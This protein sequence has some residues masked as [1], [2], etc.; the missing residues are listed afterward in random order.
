MDYP[1][2][3]TI[4]IT[5]Q[6]F[7]GLEDV[8]KMSS[9][10]V[11]KTSSPRLQRS[12]FTSSK[13]SSRRLQ[14]VLQRRL[15]D[16]SQDVFK[17]SLKTKNCYAEDVFKTS[18]RHVLKTSWRYILK[19]PSRRLG[20]KQNVYWWYL[21]LTNLNVYLTDLCLTNLYLTNL[22]QIQNALLRTQ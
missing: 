12:N 18:C 3:F 10:H 5:Q 7:V 19:T 22:R 8:L 17:T 6:T 21:Y 16:L 13:M 1:F 4:S 2:I 15:Q 9:R 20:G 11:L 14:D